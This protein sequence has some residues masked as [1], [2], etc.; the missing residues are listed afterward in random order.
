VFSKIKLGVEEW[1]KLETD[2]ARVSS[3]EPLEIVINLTLVDAQ[4]GS[5]EVEEEEEEHHH[6]HY[7]AENEFTRE[8]AAMIDHIAHTYNVHVHTHLHSHHGSVTFAVKGTPRELIKALKD[9]VEYI[10]L[11]CERCT[12]HTVDGEFH[13]G[14]DLVGIY[15]GDAYKI[16]VILPAEDGRRLKVHEVHF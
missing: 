12:L 11:N 9:A 14:E 16:T 4:G 5:E 13:L 2:L 10:K 1:K 8:V 3:G 7:I 6:E 15:F